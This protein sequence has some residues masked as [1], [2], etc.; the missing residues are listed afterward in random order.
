MEEVST[1]EWSNRASPLELPEDERPGSPIPVNR[2]ASSMS[3]ESVVAPTFE[4]I[5]R[6]V[7]GDLQLN[8]AWSFCTPRLPRVAIMRHPRVL[9]AFLRFV[10][11]QNEVALEGEAII[12]PSIP[13][14]IAQKIMNHPSITNPPIEFLD[15]IDELKERI[16]A[17]IQRTS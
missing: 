3:Y 2:S 16:E 4:P 14:D 6:E 12:L 17:L 10:A 7:D 1:I 13:L 8:E 15:D 9:L 5:F 11:L